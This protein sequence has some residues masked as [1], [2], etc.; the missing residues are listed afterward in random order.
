MVANFTLDLRQ[1]NSEIINDHA[2]S[3]PP[4]RSIRSVLQHIHQSVLVE[5]G[6][7]EG[8]GQGNSDGILGSQAEDTETP[9]GQT[10]VA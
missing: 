10:D 5:M 3:L 9:Q 1:S 8:A 4:I 7:S 6:D 2:A